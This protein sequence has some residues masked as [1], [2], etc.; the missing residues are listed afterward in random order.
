VGSRVRPVWGTPSRPERSIYRA[1]RHWQ[2]LHPSSRHGQPR[3]G[4]PNGCARRRSQDMEQF[5]GPARPMTTRDG[6]WDREGFQWRLILGADGKWVWDGRC[7]RPAPAVAHKWRWDGTS[8]VR[9]EW[10][11][12]RKLLV[13]PSIDRSSGPRRRAWM[14]RL[15][16]ADQD[17]QVRETTSATTFPFGESSTMPVFAVEDWSE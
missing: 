10:F 3:N 13:W 7:W 17:R 1:C 5:E 11:E 16:R 15:L 9:R 12:G 8:W 6:R 4:R 14:R 2:L